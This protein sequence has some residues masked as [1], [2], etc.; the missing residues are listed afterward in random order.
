MEGLFCIVYYTGPHY[1]VHVANYANSQ[2]FMNTFSHS[3]WF[4]LC[5]YGMLRY[6]K[7]GTRPTHVAQV[8]RPIPFIDPNHTTLTENQPGLIE[9]PL[10]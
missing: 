7:K 3:R 10:S 8:L 5:F 2:S 1:Y 4:K 9:R 6:L